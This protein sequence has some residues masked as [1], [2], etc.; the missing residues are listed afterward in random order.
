MICL[1]IITIIQLHVNI[2]NI[3]SNITIFE[4]KNKLIKIITLYLIFLIF[5][6]W[7]IKKKQILISVLHW[8]CWVCCFIEVFEKRLVWHR[9]KL[10]MRGPNGQ[11]EDI[12][13]SHLQNH[14][15]STELLPMIR[16]IAFK[17]GCIW[18]G[19]MGRKCRQ[20]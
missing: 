3:I 10:G 14:Y 1:K 18:G 4:T 12:L 6:V 16:S 15:L 11:H 5:K 13:R 2:N 7:L 17:N 19:G 20:L 8:V 9:L